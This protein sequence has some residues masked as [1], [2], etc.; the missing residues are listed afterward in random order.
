[1]VFFITT[2]SVNAQEQKQDS[3]RVKSISFDYALG[4]ESLPYA[5]LSGV[6]IGDN[7]VTIAQIDMTTTKTGTSVSYWKS[8]DLIGDNEGSYD[9]FF[10][11]QPFKIKKQAMKFTVI[12]FADFGLKKRASTILAIETHGGKKLKWSIQANQF[13][14]QDRSTRFVLNP[15]VSYEQISLSSWTFYEF[16]KIT[17]SLG[18]SY[19][20]KKISVSPKVNANFKIVYNTDVS[21]S[22]LRQNNTALIGVTFLQ[23]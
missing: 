21:S 18:V 19:K 17:Q 11:I 15:I 13:I 16:N 5:P 2:L 9:G 7:M 22:K 1:M 8:F 14:Y 3:I 4:F 10:A 12:Y 20:S 23:K 6:S